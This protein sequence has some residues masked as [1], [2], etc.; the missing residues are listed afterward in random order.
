[1]LI[2]PDSEV[3]HGGILISVSL[4]TWRTSLW[5]EIFDDLTGD[6][7]PLSIIHVDDALFARAARR[8]GTDLSDRAAR[9]AFLE[10]FPSRLNVQRWLAG[11]QDPG[12]ALLPLLVLCCLA[13]SEAA[14]SGANDYRRRLRDLMGWDDPIINC[15]A[16]PSLWSRLAG[17]TLR[18]AD[19]TPTRKLIL[20]DPRFRS[21]IGHAIEL[22]FPSRND[23][24]RLVQELSGATIDFDAPGAVLAWLLPLVERS[25]FSTTFAETFNDFRAAWLAAERTLADHRFWSGW[26][27]ATQGLRAAT[28]PVPFEI[29]ADEWGGRHLVDPATEAAFNL[30]QALKGRNL[31]LTL[32]AAMRNNFIPLVESEWGKLR[33]LGN[34]RYH[35]PSALLV[36][37]LAFGS[38]FDRL[39]CLSVSGAD[40]WGLTFDVVGA[41]GVR[42]PI[43]ERDRLIDVM[44][45]G[46]TR[47][48]GG[49]LARPAL[50]FFIETTGQV[51]SLSLE[52]DLANQILLTRIN[53]NTWRV[54]LKRPVDGEVRIIAEPVGGGT[55][56]D[57]GLRLRRSSLAPSFREQLSERLYD[58]EPE[59]LPGWPGVV[60]A[61]HM[62]HELAPAGLLDAAPQLLDLIEYLATQT[63]PIPLSGVIDII[64][65]AIDD[66]ATNPW[67][68]LQAFRDA[69]VVTVLNI[70][71]WRGRIVLSRSPQGFMIRTASGWS[72]MFEGCTNETWVTRLKASASHLG[73]AFEQRLGVGRWSPPTFM[74]SGADHSV[75]LEV[76]RSVDTTAHNLSSGLYPVSTLWTGVSFGKAPV[77]AERRSMAVDGHHSLIAFLEPRQANASP[78][79]AVDTCGGERYWHSRDDAILDAYASVGARPFEMSEARTVARNARLPRHVA[80]WMRLAAGVS[81][82]PVK[83]GYEYGWTAAINRELALI[84]PYFFNRCVGVDINVTSITSRRWATRAIGTTSGP[85]I[86]SVWSAARGA[87]MDR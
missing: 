16:L 18:R 20:P 15:A 4:A 78:V 45:T 27:L 57:R 28:I 71:G 65:A 49:V 83:H 6:G 25:R 23:T 5:S 21:Q 2:P 55:R 37:K 10:A 14:D 24:R 62:A 38:R 77:G 79:W 43:S 75:L 32:V 66:E 7:R 67:D 61:A 29:V 80:R 42:T 82:G 72:L 3:H 1:M 84:A 76:A 34:D 70:R 68:V 35:S 63:S 8:H 48:D 58:A 74:V 22:T 26:H 59:P 11:S 17:L 39:R 60:E 51:G 36:R 40:G 33:W 73:A 13:A 50:P 53:S 12:E 86:M 69:G 52:G 85:R 56:L 46:C 9:S 64:R 19:R 81:A 41:L 30:E 31:P 47:V 54:N 44:P 87:R